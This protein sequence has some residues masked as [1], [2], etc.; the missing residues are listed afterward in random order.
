MTA[1]YVLL[2]EAMGVNVFS[3]EEMWRWE[4]KRIQNRTLENTDIQEVVEGS[5]NETKNQEGMTC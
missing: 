4:G 5:A 1:G 2:V 3:K